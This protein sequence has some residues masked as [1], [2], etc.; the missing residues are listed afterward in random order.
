MATRPVRLRDRID[1]LIHAALTEFSLI[2]LIL[3]SIGLVFVE[4]ALQQTEQD[5]RLAVQMQAGLTIL[6]WLEL[7]T[8]YWIARSKRR[9][10]RNYWLDILAVLPAVHPFRLLRLLRVGIL[11]NRNLGRLSLRLARGVGA[12]I[13]LLVTLGL[14]L[15]TGTLGVYLLEG[16]RNPGFDSLEDALWWSVLTLVAGEPIGG[17]PL[18]LLG[19]VFTLLV[20]LGGLTMF[21]VVTGV[22][23]AVMV[24]R[25]QT[26]MEFRTVELDELRDHVVICGWNRGGPRIIEELLFDPTMRACA[27]VIVAEFTET[28]EAMLHH[29]NLSQLYCQS[30]D[31]TRVDVLETVGII[32]ASRAI[33]LADTSR[34][35]S[36]Q[37]RDARTVL[38]ALTIEK[39]NP[40]IYTCAQLLD[41]NNDVQLKIAGVDDVIVA[42][43]LASHLI[44]T[45]ARNQ[46]SVEVL[47]ELLTVQIGNQFYK[48]PVPPHWDDLTF[49]AAAERLKTEYDALLV[50][51]ETSL[52]TR[53][54]LVNP[55]Q[56]YRLRTGD[57]L[58]IIARREPDLVQRRLRRR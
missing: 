10:F 49:W 35:R 29:L 14:I 28:P 38:A 20:M 46:G 39:L 24:Q 41:R 31:Y 56:D 45:S 1:Q 9:F 8:R 6:F 17:E 52:P 51:V 2:G 32:H 21:A 25:L 22:V 34:P 33:L 36:D 19:R 16:G 15:L 40:A 27:V 58:V 48:V 50:A 13:G 54:T 23:S 12:Q 5:Y 18:T 7:A 4:V 44:A 3:L 53:K 30:G 47:T 43:E 55:E 37:D 57:R 42:D 26:V 11:L